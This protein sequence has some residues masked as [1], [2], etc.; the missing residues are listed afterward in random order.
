[1]EFGSG[2][3]GSAAKGRTDT[4]IAD[5]ENQQRP[6]GFARRPALSDQRSNALDAS[7]GPIIV[8]GHRRVFRSRPYAY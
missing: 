8:E 3:M 2:H 7:D 1:M 6:Q 5:I 4:E